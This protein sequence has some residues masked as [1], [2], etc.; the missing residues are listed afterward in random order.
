MIC[1]WCMHCGSYDEDYFFDEERYCGICANQMPEGR[2]GWL[3]ALHG[4]TPAMIAVVE[5]ELN[6]IGA[7]KSGL[8]PEVVAGMADAID[9]F[10]RLRLSE[11]QDYSGQSAEQF[12]RWL[13]FACTYYPPS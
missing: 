6:K 3:A 5:S 1:P 4:L 7:S 11:G 9:Q 10:T 8:Q 2:D 12:A 13:D